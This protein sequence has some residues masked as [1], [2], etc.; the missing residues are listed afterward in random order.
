MGNFWQMP[1]GMA[2]YASSQL[3]VSFPTWRKTALV[4]DLAV[5]SYTM[6]PGQISG[7]GITARPYN[8]PW[9]IPGYFISVKRF[10]AVIVGVKPR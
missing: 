4:A 9:H 7:I 6:V 10:C 5:F 1:P 3:L 8:S 2:I